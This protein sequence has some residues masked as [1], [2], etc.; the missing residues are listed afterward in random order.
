MHVLCPRLTVFH[1]QGHHRLRISGEVAQGYH[2][3]AGTEH[4]TAYPHIKESSYR[5]L[6]LYNYILQ[7]IN[8][9]L[10]PQVRLQ[11]RFLSIP[12]RRLFREMLFTDIQGYSLQSQKRDLSVPCHLKRLGHFA[13]QTGTLVKH[14]PN[15]TPTFKKS[16]SR[17][18]SVLE[19]TRGH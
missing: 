13:I 8:Y 6:F 11:L 19:L 12:R 3:S 7:M 5:Q 9:S 18:S 2:L 17:V 10:A 4:C 15:A 16:K 14:I 1:K